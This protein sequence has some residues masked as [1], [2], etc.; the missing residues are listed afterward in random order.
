MKAP[1]QQLPHLQDTG[2]SSE[3]HRKPGA[4][5]ALTARCSSETSS[6][7]RC[8]R[9]SSNCFG[10]DPLCLLLE[11]IGCGFGN[12]LFQAIKA[13][14][15]QKQDKTKFTLH[16]IKTKDVKKCKHSRRRRTP[17]GKVID[18]GS[19]GWQ[20]RARLRVWLCLR[21]PA[22]QRTRTCQ[23][24]RRRTSSRRKTHEIVGRKF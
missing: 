13:E 5:G 18:E 14:I 11:D 21:S 8:C 6:P 17:L 4:A 20:Q 9:C 1:S 23:S 22:E 12:G 19:T 10:H 2:S 15:I 7:V 3:I 16:L 24:V